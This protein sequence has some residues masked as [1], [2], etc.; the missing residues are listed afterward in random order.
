MLKNI[1]TTVGSALLVLGLLGNDVYGLPTFELNAQ[2][3]NA[4]SGS[5]V[6][7]VSLQMKEMQAMEDEYLR[8]NEED[9]EGARLW[10]RISCAE[11]IDQ[12]LAI[13][14]EFGVDFTRRYKGQTM[15]YPAGSVEILEYL[16][17]LELFDV[18]SLDN[19]GNSALM[20]HVMWWLG[21]L[22]IYDRVCEINGWEN[23]PVAIQL[24]GQ[25]GA[26]PSFIG[27]GGKTMLQLVQESKA[28]DESRY[29]GTAGSPKDRMEE[30]Y[31]V[32]SHRDVIEKLRELE[33]N[34]PDRV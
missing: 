33:E 25:A 11:T 16:I 26:N 3:D 31:S 12:F 1:K 34:M 27:S 30:E 21:R 9:P 13:L 8:G 10:Y 6:Q 7:A 2:Q 5:Y 23:L 24:F 28:Y 32:Q 17:D 4:E 22:D 18:N 19:K 15:L 29:R 14:Q 20:F